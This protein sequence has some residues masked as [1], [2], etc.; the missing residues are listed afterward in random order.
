[1][2]RPRMSARSST[3]F[4]SL[5]EQADSLLLQQ[6]EEPRDTSHDWRP[7]RQVVVAVLGE[8]WHANVLSPIDGGPPKELSGKTGLERKHSGLLI[9][10]H[11]QV[12]G[13]D[14]DHWFL[15]EWLFQRFPGR[16]S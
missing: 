10:Q 2:R 11:E 15:H 12:S 7:G 6:A 16:R 3:R 13:L 4:R 5:A 8:T 9:C 14:S 1:M